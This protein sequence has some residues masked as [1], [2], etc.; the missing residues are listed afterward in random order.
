MY[1]YILNLNVNNILKIYLNQ[2]AIVMF[3]FIK[4]VQKLK[5]K[6][7]KDVLINIFAEIQYNKYLILK[8]QRNIR[9]YLIEK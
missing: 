1:R 6:K 4:T 5:K 8:N 2:I 7:Q 9:L 3:N